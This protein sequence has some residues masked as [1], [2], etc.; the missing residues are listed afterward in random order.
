ME[1]EKIL[2]VQTSFL[3]D[4]ILSTPVIAGISERHQGAEIYSLTTVLGA[5]LL[6]DDPLLAGQ[7]TYDKGG[8]ERGAFALLRKAAELRAFEFNS[9][10]VL[11]RSYRTALLLAL[12]GIK[13]KVGFEDASLP[14]VYSERHRRNFGSHDVERNF[15]ILGAGFSNRA[16]IMELR[17]FA[18]GV[19]RVS[20]EVSE[21]RARLGRYAVLFPGSAWKTKRW[22]ES[23]FRGLI[24]QLPLLGLGACVMGAS[25][26][27]Q[28][29][30]SICQGMAVEN[31]CG[32][33][34][35]AELLYI[36][37]NA[38][39]AVCNDSMALHVA[40]AFKVPTVAVFCSTSPDFGFGPWRNR[41]EI[42]ERIGLSCKPCGRHGHRECPL[43]TEQCMRE[44]SVAAVAEAARRV[45]ATDSIAMG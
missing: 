15:S 21:A 17:L 35:I 38:S 33:T 25:S 9:A 32:R 5:E 6:R 26:E 45:L 14:W 22:H 10:Y 29:C 18:P 39:L 3:G 13:S 42:V 31:L 41:A 23:G 24:A 11:H 34:T 4:V 28:I 16:D 7:L 1:R 36:V 2:L 12:S 37:R 19:E 27:I 20:R 30:N 43:G 44:V 8:S 40:S